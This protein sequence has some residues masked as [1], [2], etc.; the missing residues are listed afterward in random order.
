MIKPGAKSCQA[1]NTPFFDWF[2]NLPNRVVE[3]ARPHALEGLRLFSAALGLFAAT[4]LVLA[5]SLAV[6]S[7]TFGC[8]VMVRETGRWAVS[9]KKRAPATRRQARFP[10]WRPAPLLA[11]V[12]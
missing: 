5:G 3:A 10:R 9:P 7:L 8:M 4:S 11:T 12:H 2:C 1:N 6:S